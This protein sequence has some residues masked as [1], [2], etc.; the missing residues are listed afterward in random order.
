MLAVMPLLHRAVASLQVC[1]DHLDPATVTRS[2]GS[3]PTLS[4][5]RGDQVSAGQGSR[6]ARFG[7]WSLEA[8]A[9]EPADIDAQVAHLLGRVTNDFEVWRE[10]SEQFSIRLFCGWF[11][12]SGNEGL[13]IAPTTLALT[14]RRIVLDVDMYAR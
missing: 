12:R 11:M 7:L 3:A 10:L 5:A 8:P 1:G 9:T 6:T 13:V 14:E 2:L 4:Y